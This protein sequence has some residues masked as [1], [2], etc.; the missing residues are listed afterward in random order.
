M[1]ADG[2]YEEGGRKEE[3]RAWIIILDRGGL[4]HIKNEAYQLFYLMEVEVKKNLHTEVCSDQWYN[5]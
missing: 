3:S 2:D 4:V 5:S 1:E